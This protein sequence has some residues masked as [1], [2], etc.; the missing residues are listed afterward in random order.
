MLYSDGW[1]STV[2]LQ[3][4]VGRQTDVFSE[5]KLLYHFD[6]KFTGVEITILFE[7]CCV[8]ARSYVADV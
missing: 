8:V 1:A 3:S 7:S 6:R 4:K 5:R 2:D